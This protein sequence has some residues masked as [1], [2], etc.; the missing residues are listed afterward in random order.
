MPAMACCLLRADV[1]LASERCDSK[2][3]QLCLRI[4]FFV[5]IRA[6]A[7]SIQASGKFVVAILFGIETRIIAV[8]MLM[9]ALRHFRTS[10][11]MK[12]SRAAAIGGWLVAFTRH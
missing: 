6:L 12:S 4:A 2:T 9:A 8:V 3:Q 5:V 1:K 11:N 7:N 10:L